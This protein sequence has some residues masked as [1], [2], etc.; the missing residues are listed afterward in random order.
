MSTYRYDTYT[1]LQSGI[2]ATNVVIKRIFVNRI[3][4][5]MQGKEERRPIEENVSD[6]DMILCMPLSRLNKVGRQKK[7]HQW[8]GQTLDYKSCLNTFF[9]KLNRFRDARG[10][11]GTVRGGP[12]QSTGTRGIVSRTQRFFSPDQSGRANVVCLCARLAFRIGPNEREGANGALAPGY[13]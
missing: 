1:I 6:S 12:C 11:S 8:L 13:G 7:L 9:R 3:I 10:G 4:L 5:E 2:Q